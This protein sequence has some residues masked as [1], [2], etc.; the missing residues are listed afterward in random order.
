MIFTLP[1]AVGELAV[2]NPRLIYGLLFEAASTAVQEMAADPKHLGAQVGMVAVLHTWG[3]TL[4]LHPH[5]HVL[6][7][8]GGL[9]CDRGGRLDEV[10]LWRGSRPGFFLPVR[11][12]SRLF[13]GK[14]LAG[15]RLAQEQGR[16]RLPLQLQTAGKWAAWLRQQHAQDWVVYSQPPCA[17]PE[18]VLKYLARYVYRVAI[19]NSRLVEV[20]AEEVTFS[21]KDYRQ[22]GK[23]KE[24]TLSLGEFA[25]R[26]VQ[27]V[28]PGGFVRVRHY[29]LLSNRGWEE[30]LQ[31]CR[32][33]LGGTQHQ[34]TASWLV[35]VHKEQCRTCRGCGEGRMEVV[36]LLA[37]QAAVGQAAGSRELDDT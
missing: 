34:E 28:L 30:K 18:V 31:V 22:G 33:L 14:F 23:Q 7:T 26:F 12:L 10:P 8:G 35:P 25:R 24:M 19:S 2:D 1:R 37:R 20:S 9:S 5:L 36:G 6:A 29:G 17:G 11:A 13:R 3:Q 4:C 32:R 21:Y 16:L 27:H 15:L